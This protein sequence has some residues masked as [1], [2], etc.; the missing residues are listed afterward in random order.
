[1]GMVIP[2][3]RYP[4]ESLPLVMLAPMVDEPLAPWTM[5]GKVLVP[6]TRG[7]T[8][9][10]PRHPSTPEAGQ[11]LSASEWAAQQFAPVQLGDHRLN[12]RALEM[13]A[14][15]AAHP[16]ASLPNQMEG[17]SALVG[18]YR[19]LNS[20][21][22]TMEALLAPHR[23]QTLA[24]AGRYPAVLLVE[25]TTELDYTTHASKRGLGP[26]GD[27]KGKGLLLH[28]TL[29][30]VPQDRRVLG[31]AHAQVVTREPTPKPAPH[32]KRSAEAQVWEVSARSVGEPPEGVIWVHVS[33]CGSDI[34]E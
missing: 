21:Q 15:M 28:S 13:G 23:Q 29:A 10:L 30:V 11:V 1:M 27:G 5:T 7:A 19:V 22:V 26:I 33:D 25:D 3:V 17:R 12:R 9:G 24:A 18:A 34:F 8:E 6:E 2:G 16:A 32:W 4:S 31:V 20:E 14:K